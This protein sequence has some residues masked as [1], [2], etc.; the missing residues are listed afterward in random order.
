MPRYEITGPDGARYEVTAPEGASEK[1]ILSFVQKNVGGEDFAAKAAGLSPVEL[2]NARVKNDDFGNYLREQAKA[3]KAGE[4][5]EQTDK[6]LYGSLGYQKPGQAEGLAR[7]FNQGLTFGFG[8]EAQAALNAAFDPILRKESM[9]GTFGDRYKT[10]LASERGRLKQYSDENPV[11]AAAAE[12]VGAIPTAVATAPASIPASVGGRIALGAAGGAAQGAVYGFGTGEGGAEDRAANSA[13]PA[14]L[15]GVVGALAP[16]VG[17]GARAIGNRVATGRAA[18]E[19]GVSRPAYELLTRTLAADD[20]LTGAGAQRMAAAGPGAMLADA[21]PNARGMLDTIIQRSGPASS[22]ATRAVEG[23]AAQAGQQINQALDTTFGAPAGVGTTERAIRRGSQSARSSAYRAAYERPIDYST[24]EGQQIERLIA[25]RVPGDAIRRANAL[26]RA[27]GE[28]SAQI[29]ADIA[30]DG[31]VTF[32][33]MPDVRQIDYITRGLNEVADQADGQGRLGGQTQLGRAYSNL[34][35]E[36]RDL[37]RVSVP[38]YGTA[39]DTAAEPI[40]ARNALRFGQEML[41]ARTLRDDVAQQVAGMSQAERQMVGQGIRSQ[42]DDTLANVRR[43]VTDPNMD[44]RE[45]V[46][47]VKDLSSRAAR[48][49][50][51]LVIGD[52]AADTLFGQLD[53]AAMA[54]ELRAGVAQ[55]SKTFTRQAMNEQAQAMTDDGVINALRSGKPVNAGQRFVQM[56]F[57][58]TAADKSRIRDELDS[59]MTRALVGPDG[60][61]LLQQIA[62]MQGRPAMEADRWRRLGEIVARRNPAISAPV[63]ENAQR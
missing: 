53:Q 54:L 44:A 9:G 10:Y 14:A 4:T 61:R 11:K 49:K 41:S 2:F 8:D 29:L 27:E 39:L 52:N 38:E 1:D 16:A 46:K 42:I 21:G 31:S 37:T 34:S 33:Q 7:S 17:A 36:L 5:K 20:S 32:R 62:N 48:E 13:I 51:A 28:S 43:A 12:I 58:R 57:N 30:E 26:M 59:E 19:A 23:R 22:E 35:R 18:Q 45:A 63:S 24:A 15:G 56:L 6:R 25:E 60:V 3:P 47:A 40:A 55:N 50:V